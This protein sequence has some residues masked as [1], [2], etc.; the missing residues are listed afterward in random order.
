MKIKTLYSY[1]LTTN[2][3]CSC[4][5]RPLL[6]DWPMK[7]TLTNEIAFDT[8]KIRISTIAISII[9]IIVFVITMLCLQIHLLRAEQRITNLVLSSQSVIHANYFNL[10]LE[11]YKFRDN[12]RRAGGAIFA[13][14]NWL[15][16]ASGDGQFVKVDISKK[17][18]QNDYLPK[19]EMGETEIETSK[20][21]TYKELLPRVHDVVYYNNTYYVSYDRYVVKDDA[22]HFVISRLH[23]SDMK[24]QDIYYSLPLDV[25]YYALG[26]GGKMAVSSAKSKLFFTVGD[27]S[28]DRLN[29]L[30]S[31]IAPQNKSLPWGKVNCIDLKSGSIIMYSY[32][33]RN[34]MGLLMMDDG[35]LLESENGPR[36]GDELNIIRAG[37]NY[38]WP[39]QS[40]GIKYDSWNSYADGLLEPSKNRY[41]APTFAFV[42]SIAPTSLIQIKNFDSKW[43]HDILMG[44]LKAQSLFHIKFLKDKVLYSEQVYIGK[45]IRDLKQINETIILLD[46]ESH[47]IFLR[48]SLS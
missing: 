11:Q 16:Y 35:R 17:A 29:G 45:R 22:I 30:P 34:P 7:L 24:W 1:V 10:K 4:S 2:K 26:N 44:S 47:L 41:I 23:E 28:L 14:D 18:Y 5:I 15:L 32:G 13:R 19:L 48:K 9:R 27:Y 33:H 40:Y 46:D 39:Y 37:G 12:F 42:P 36:G 38:G 43:D 3:L 31:D 6:A 20:R 8:T 21:I 25:P